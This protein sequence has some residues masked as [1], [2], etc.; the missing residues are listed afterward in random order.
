M[1]A[2][3]EHTQQTGAPDSG[4]KALARIRE[5][6]KGNGLKDSDIEILRFDPRTLEFPAIIALTLKSETATRKQP[7]K[8][9]GQRVLP[10]AVALQAAL[11]QEEQ[12]IAGN[13]GTVQDI[14]RAILESP[15]AG[16][17]MAEAVVKLPF[18]RQ[19]YIYYET[20]GPCGG[21]G[22]TVCNRCNGKGNEQCG[23][24]YGAALEPC[25]SCGG[26]RVLSDGQGN[27]PCV[28]CNATGKI[29]CTQC[30][31]TRVVQ[32]P[33]CKGKGNRTCQQ[34]RGQ[35][36]NSVITNV[37]MSVQARFDFDR[38]GLSLPL[39]GMIERAGPALAQQAENLPAPP[40]AESGGEELH[41]RYHVRLP[42][43]EAVFKVGEMEIPALVFGLQADLPDFPPFLETLLR[44]AMTALE[45]AAG[46]RSGAEEAIRRAG[47]V[48]ALRYALQ[49]VA[50]GGR[51]KAARALLKKFPVGL[52]KDGA[53]ALAGLAEAALR[54]ISGKSGLA[55]RIVPAAAML[56]VSGFYAYGARPV[57]AGFLPRPEF[58]LAADAAIFALLA[59]AAFTLGQ[60]CAR[61]GMEKRLETLLR[62]PSREG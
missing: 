48:R 55:C 38:T 58:G 21:R 31:Q 25:P 46:S 54:N 49:G 36:A 9:S 30:Q 47:R 40:Q 3:G 6:A 42:V 39:A 32:C 33:A 52:S 19:E 27:R 35:T 13:P 56:A 61:Q 18:L 57:V 28:R 1:S 34:C 14:R 29:P 59:F 51:K 62:R 22:R 16:P 60:S 12:A 8:V 2:D 45:A 11:R 24:C 53:E 23:R 50:R 15:G 26:R 4:Q 44:P 37:E 5:E 10:N 41:I 43:A 17:G 20:C 7:G